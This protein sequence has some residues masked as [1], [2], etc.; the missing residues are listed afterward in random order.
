M[1]R[2][3][4]K[5]A[6]FTLPDGKRKYIYAKTQEELDQKVFNLKL[7]LNAGVDLND[8]T[9][10][11]E[12]IKMWFTAEVQPNIQASTETNMRRVINAHLL[13]L[14]SAAVA[15]DVTPMQVKRWINEFNKLNKSAAQVC[16]R[17]VREAFALAEENGLVYRSP[18]LSRFKATG[19]PLNKR[20]ALTPAEEQRLLSVVTDPQAHLLVWLALATGMRRGELLG[21]MWDCV[22]LELGVIEVRRNLVLIGNEILF[23]D[24]PKTEAGHRTLPIP[25][26][27]CDALRE[28]RAKSKSMMV[29]TNHF[30]KPYSQACFFHFW[31]SRVHEPYGSKTVTPH[32]LRHTFATRCF[33]SGMDIKEVQYLMGHATADLTLGVYT[34][35]CQESRQDATFEKAREARAGLG[36]GVAAPQKVYPLCTTPVPQG[37][38]KTG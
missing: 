11:G 36:S 8:K 38:V 6:T 18:V 1:A 4:Y 26:D 31:A 16:M 17:G 5:T 14:V 37:A 34:H 27:L 7:Q 23:N 9:T 21:L 15:K 32:V 25:Q 3:G 35:Y 30:G 33:E 2:K 28:W 12:L 24:H 20:E 29:F 13:P 10:V 22:D 19:K